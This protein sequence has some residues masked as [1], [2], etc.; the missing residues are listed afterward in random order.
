MPITLFH[1]LALVALFTVGL[2]AQSDPAPPTLTDKGLI[3]TRT[4][5][6]SYNIEAP[7][8][9]GPNKP[10]A[11]RTLQEID[12]QNN[13]IDLLTQAMSLAK[14]DPKVAHNLFMAA[15]LRAAFDMERVDDATARGAWAYLLNQPGPA[16]LKLWGALT[17]KLGQADHQAVVAWARSSGPPAYHPSWMI[18]HGMRAING[19]RA[20]GDNGLKPG[21]EP[22]AAWTKVCDQAART[23]EDASYWT[24][25]EKQ[26]SPESLQALLQFLEN[27]AGQNLDK[28]APSRAVAGRQKMREACVKFDP[29]ADD[30]A[31]HF[32][33]AKTALD[34]IFEECHAAHLKQ[35]D[36][37]AAKQKAGK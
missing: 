1:R 10:F 12:P 29:R 11:G 9:L 21:F 35:R 34:R 3:V 8:N 16:Q 15:S 28:R 4:G 13:P 14:E 31:W 32:I 33:E 26:T 25:R 37:E 2:G 24:A 17:R 5:P 27:G 6:R 20:K 23:A 18:Q 7:G 19:D 22:V 30:P 36:E